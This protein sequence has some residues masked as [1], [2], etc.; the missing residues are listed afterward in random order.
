MSDGLYTASDFLFVPA[1]REFEMVAQD[2]VADGLASA[3][4]T[5]A[6]LWVEAAQEGAISLSLSDPLHRA[7]SSLSLRRH[8]LFHRLHAT[9]I[10]IPRTRSSSTSPSS[11]SSSVC[12]AF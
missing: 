10:Q 12:R 5:Q 8:I 9:H 2:E 3:A 11:M 4:D 1:Q 6:Q 7:R